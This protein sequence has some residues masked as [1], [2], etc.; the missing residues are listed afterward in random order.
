VRHP[1]QT[2]LRSASRSPLPV[3]RSKV[4]DRQISPPPTADEL[5]SPD[6]IYLDF[7]PIDISSYYTNG[8]AKPWSALPL[9]SQA[10]AFDLN[11]G[12]NHA[13]FSTHLLMHIHPFFFHRKFRNRRPSCPIFASPQTL[14]DRLLQPHLSHRIIESIFQQHH[15]FLKSLSLHLPAAELRNLCVEFDIPSVHRPRLTPDEDPDTS[16]NDG[17]SLSITC[18]NPTCSAPLNLS[19]TDPA[20]CTRCNT[21]RRP[22]PICLSFKAPHPNANAPAAARSETTTPA[23]SAHGLWTFCQSCGHSA[24]VAC[25]EAWLCRPTTQGECPSAGCGHDCADG[26]VRRRRVASLAAAAS[27]SVGAGT[28]AAGEKQALD[29]K[30]RNGNGGGRRSGGSA[31]PGGGAKGEKNAASSSSMKDTWKAPQSAAVERTRG[32]LRSSVGSTG[33]GTGSESD[34]EFA[35]GGGGGASAGGRK[36]VRLMTPGEERSKAG[37]ESSLP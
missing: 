13:Q 36:V 32:L 26:E 6:H 37:E 29:G 22:C 35:R 14:A 17:V 30:S 34:R 5:Q 11:L 28:G 20:S 25:M 21:P 2:E 4:T 27:S 9:I 10:I 7:Q 33:T 3:P 16:L 24:H 23:T 15:T 8:H 1:V 12:E 19:A 18:T 31:D